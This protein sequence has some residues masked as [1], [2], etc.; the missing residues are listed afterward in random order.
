VRIRFLVLIAAALAFVAFGPT[1]ARSAS[2]EVVY[3]TTYAGV[4]AYDP[5]T[6]QQL[7][8][9]TLPSGSQTSGLAVHAGTIFV[10]LYN[11]NPDSYEVAEYPAGAKSPARYVAP[12]QELG[13]I[14]VSR[15]G[16]LAIAGFGGGSCCSTSTL[17]FY[18]ARDTKPNRLFY[19]NAGSFYYVA[20]DAAGTCW[21]EGFNAKNELSFGYVAAGRKKIVAVAFPG[22]L[23]AGP[24]AIDT[25]GNIVLAGS[26]GR[27]QV[28]SPG[29]ALL[30]QWTLL[31]NPTASGIAVSEDG[32]RLYVSDSATQ[33]ATYRYPS[34]ERPLAFFGTFASDVAVAK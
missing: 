10:G 30:D 19:R 15:A 9:L 21:I 7:G 14:A 24:I 17:T 4:A 26:S 32:K 34:G 3:A 2:S 1:T 29:G 16:E 18:A 20:Y 28:F 25:A 13:N 33:I 23:S 12:N 27:I 31:G 5:F 22:A 8:L 6:G 11:A